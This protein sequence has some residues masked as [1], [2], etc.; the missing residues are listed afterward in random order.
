MPYNDSDAYPAMIPFTSL[1]TGPAPRDTPSGRELRI[2]ALCK[3]HSMPTESSVH[4]GG[5]LSSD[6]GIQ[7]RR[8]EDWIK[9]QYRDKIVWNFDPAKFIQAVWGFGREDVPP[10][11]FT[12]AGR[13]SESSAPPSF[14]KV[15][16]RGYILERREKKCSVPLAKIANGL[17]DQMYGAK[18]DRQG[19]HRVLPARFRRRDTKYKDERVDMTFSTGELTRGKWPQWDFEAAFLEVKKTKT[20]PVLSRTELQL[21]DTDAYRVAETC[22]RKRTSAEDGTEL[23]KAKRARCTPLDDLDAPAA[24]DTQAKEDT[25]M[26][27][28]EFDLTHNEAQAVRYMNHMMSSNVRS[29]GI[30]WLVEDTNMCLYY[31]DRMGIVV[32]R[33]FRFLHDER[34]LFV[35]CIAAMGQA[36][37]HGM[38]IFPDLHFPENKQKETE[39]ERYEGSRLCITAR[40]PDASEPEP[41]EFDVDVDGKTRWIYTQFGA[42]GRGTSIIPIK[43]TP[44]TN[45]YRCFK[46][47]K[48]VAKISWPDALRS[49]EDSL[50]IAVRKR[51]SE[52]KRQY[53]P[54]IVDLKCSVTRTIEEM[55]LP[56]AAMGLDRDEADERVCRVLV[57]QCY[58]RLEAVES[59][60][61]FKKVYT[62]VVRAHY[63]VW[64]TSRILHRDISTN[65]IMWIRIDGKLYGVLCDWDLAEENIDGNIPT[66]RAH[67]CAG[68]EEPPVSASNTSADDTTTTADAEPKKPR[69]RTGTGPFMAVD[70]LRV[71]PP[72]FHLYR[73]DLEAFFYVLVYVCAVLN[74]RKR[75]FGHLSGWER[76]TLVEIGFN[77]KNFLSSLD[78]YRATFRDCDPAFKPLIAPKSWVWTLYKHFGKVE[79][80]AVLILRLHEEARMGDDLDVEEITKLEEQR[81]EEI[82]YAR[83]MA[84][85]G[86]PEDVPDADAHRVAAP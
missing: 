69:Y 17:L 60:E 79:T 55:K 67:E 22:K 61:D 52:A 27:P 50:I 59:V 80:W 76:E 1:P 15:S 21:V 35:R 47:D 34:E 4:T 7:W 72:P 3:P 33:K 43:A 2:T 24:E 41:F 12:S 65:N 64:T 49:A 75:K 20:G 44:K 29:F 11:R 83:F 48:L 62:D 56:R 5:V 13:P 46:T 51:L 38:G 39:F 70:L 58:Q 85:L 73:H 30:G 19:E 36:D 66:T 6:N 45:T 74:L 9:E 14:D 23:P 63:W 82:T 31:G 28:Q 26:R 54:H 37:V 40:R 71:G 81:D 32:T 53:L 8:H 42:L 25:P 84:I 18:S 16:L 10:R 77:K 57:M 68:A 78:V 86:A